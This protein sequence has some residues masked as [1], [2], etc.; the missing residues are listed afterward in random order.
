M[1]AQKNEISGWKNFLVNA[2]FHC[3]VLGMA[4]VLA[5]IVIGFLT[6]CLGLPKI[7]FYIVLGSGLVL[8]ISW[9][10]FCMRCNCSNLRPGKE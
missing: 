4:G 8:G 3:M 1:N 6:C 10:A 7:V 9:S 2:G 5:L